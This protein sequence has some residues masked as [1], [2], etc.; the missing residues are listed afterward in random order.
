MIHPQRSV[1]HFR[2]WP[3]RTQNIAPLR[4]YQERLHPPSPS[5]SFVTAFS[6]FVEAGDERVPDLPAHELPVPAVAHDV[7]LPGLALNQRFLGLLKK[8]KIGLGNN[9][10]IW[11]PRKGPLVSE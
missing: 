2:C 10:E 11:G 9:V 8:A 3:G 7:R 6:E 5:Q 4:V 1:H